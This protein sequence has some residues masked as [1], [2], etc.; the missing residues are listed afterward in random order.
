MLLFPAAQRMKPAF[1]V[2]FFLFQRRMQ[3]KA[4]DARSEVMSVL[5]RV[6]FEE[7]RDDGEKLCLK[8]REMQTEF[9]TEVL[10]PVPSMSRMNSVGCKIE[11]CIVKCEQCFR[12]QLQMNPN[13]IQTIRRYAQFLLEVCVGL[14]HCLQFICPD[15]SRFPSAW[16]TL[17]LERALRVG[18]CV[19]FQLCAFV[20]R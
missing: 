20:C 7:L 6:K 2:S 11:E 16:V 15:W 12:M 17:S 9:W 18:A 3:A 5:Q 8:A 1:D 19:P 13:S 14:V 10:K 4:V